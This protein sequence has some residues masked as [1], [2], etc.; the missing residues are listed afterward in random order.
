MTELIA[1]I[2]MIEPKVIKPTIPIFKLLGDFL[3]N[4]KPKKSEINPKH[5]KQK[6]SA[7]IISI[8]PD[9]KAIAIIKNA[10]MLV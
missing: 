1:R 10:I 7:A 4:I 2:Q 6:L 9:K 8:N 3:V 5:V